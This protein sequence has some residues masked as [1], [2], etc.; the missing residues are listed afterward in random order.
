MLGVV[1]LLMGRTGAPPPSLGAWMLG[2][3]PNMTG[4]AR[5]MLGAT[6]LANSTLLVVGGCDDSITNMSFRNLPSGLKADL[7]A[8]PVTWEPIANMSTGRAAFGLTTLADGRALAA[9]GLGGTTPAGLA[10]LSSAEIF[11]PR[12]SKWTPVKSMSRPRVQFGLATLKSGSVLAAGGGGL[13]PNGQPANQADAEMYHP[14]TDTW[15][16]VAD[17]T[18]PR[19]GHAATTLHDGRVVVAGGVNP[20][21]G[22]ELATAEAFD[23]ATG[24]WTAIA[25]MH[26]ND[27]ANLGL[28]TL[29]NGMVMAV[30][31]SY[32]PYA[33]L[34][35]PNADGG[36]WGQWNPLA[37]LSYP[38]S[39]LGLVAL[40]NGSAV[41]TGGSD[42][43]EA[44]DERGSELWIPRP[45]YACE[46]LSGDYYC[47][48]TKSFGH[49]NA[50]EN[51]TGCEDSCKAP[52]P[53]P[54]PL[55]YLCNA[56]MGGTGAGT[57]NVSSAY[58]STNLSECQRQCAAP[59]FVC[60]VAP[61]PINGRCVQLAHGGGLNNSV[62]N[63]TCGL[64]P[65]TWICNHTTHTC[66]ET[67]T[68]D[69]IGPTQGQCV[70]SCGGPPP[71]PPKTFY[72][73][74]NNKCEQSVSGK[75][76]LDCMTVCH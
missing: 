74:I 5:E 28:V 75:P 15:T 71:P 41:A 55:T 16:K 70:A 38:R 11:D 67:T 59:S 23:P 26:S 30:G 42:T 35:D 43:R 58:G 46:G 50:T 69:P 4:P 17:M 63:T 7:L 31:G 47:M 68:R 19:N 24:K 29:A 1:F 10:Q 51:M 61:P 18:T 37:P 65:F 44:F 9:G 3:V 57:C 48:A 14:G 52:P 2:S 62:C 33:E 73:C 49:A 64:D 54:P 20:T 39:K 25:S 6:V 56:D 21:N 34:W 22:A 32:T 13:F 76:Q 40:P 12:T 72:Q 66:H 53:A 36:P 8:S 27:R 45:L 60:H